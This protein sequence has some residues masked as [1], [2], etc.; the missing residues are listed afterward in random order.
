M[1]FDPGLTIKLKNEELKDWICITMH[2]KL[3]RVFTSTECD[4]NTFK[5]GNIKS[6]IQVK[7]LIIVNL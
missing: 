1:I 7:E 2:Y 6:N 3:P 4:G 5:V